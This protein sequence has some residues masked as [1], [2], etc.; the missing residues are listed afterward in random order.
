[1]AAAS[2]R[3]PICKS[4]STSACRKHWCSRRRRFTHNSAADRSGPD[5]G[6]ERPAANSWYRRTTATPTS[7]DGTAGRADCRSASENDGARFHGRLEKMLASAMP[8]TAD[9]L[10]QWSSFTVEALPGGA[11]TM[12]LN[13]GTGQVRI[14]GP[15]TQA[16]A[17]RSVVEALDAP[18]SATGSHPARGHE[19]NDA[20]PRAADAGSAPGA[21]QQ[22]PRR[23]QF[24]G[25]DVAAAQQDQAEADADGH[26]RRPTGS[27]PAQPDETMQI[28][29][30]TAQTAIDAARWPRRP[31]GCSG[32]WMSSLSKV[33]T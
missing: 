31:A 27:Q 24:S 16:A 5:S 4:P 2:C 12:S 18:P 28:T 3:G 29:P 21:R 15:T 25:S 33:S 23:G 6:C 30:G 19:T 7:S 11:I 26:S 20:R 10:G 22:R 17:W 13:A 1:M 32:R 14:D 8:A 9:A